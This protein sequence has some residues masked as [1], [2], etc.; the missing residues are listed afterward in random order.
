[1]SL[2]YFAYGSNMNAA[3]M[4][5]RGLGVE[6]SLAGYIDGLA[7]AFNKRAS[8][9]PH[10]SYANV[11]YSPKGRVEGV[12][13]ELSEM[14]EIF[15]MDPFEGTPRLYSRDIYLVNT[16]E[17]VIPAWVYVAN[18]AMIAEDLMPARWYLEHLLS[19]QEYLSVDY[20]KALQAVPCLD[21]PTEPKRW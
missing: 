5:A 2:Y 19:G 6:R 15:K 18:S 3:R 17:G 13:Y 16:A 21:E 8:D 20:Y 14:T 10:R 4:A 11:V 1:M 12:L 9:A 7:L